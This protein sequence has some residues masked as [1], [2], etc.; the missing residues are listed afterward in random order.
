MPVRHF[1]MRKR[2]LLKRRKNKGHAELYYH[3]LFHAAKDEIGKPD[4]LPLQRAHF[5]APEL[6]KTAVV[7]KPKP[8]LVPTP[9]LVHLC[10]RRARP[11]QQRQPA[12]VRLQPL[13]RPVVPRH[14]NKHRPKKTPRLNP[15]HN[16]EQVN[17]NKLKPAV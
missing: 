6:V 12:E 7:G 3:R 1:A 2:P 9:P 14:L 11:H 8:K 16:K 15:R 10:R 4:L 5:R 13:F 17:K